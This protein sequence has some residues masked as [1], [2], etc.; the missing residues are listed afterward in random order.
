MEQHNVSTSALTATSVA[1]IRGPLWS[2]LSEYAESGVNPCSLSIMCGHAP[3]NE[4]N[5][6]KVNL[7]KL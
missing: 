6:R 4:Q 2:L 3:A 7:P 1:A 5:A